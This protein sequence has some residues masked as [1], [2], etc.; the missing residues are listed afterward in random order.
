MFGRT[1][2]TGEIIF[3]I[4]AVCYILVAI[5]DILWNVIKDN[6]WYLLNSG[7]YAGIILIIAIILAP[8]HSFI[9]LF[10]PERLTHFGTLN[11]YHKL[12][13]YLSVILTVV[14]TIDHWERIINDLHSMSVVTGFILGFLMILIMI[15]SL[16]YFRRRHY[17]SVFIFSHWIILA[18]LIITGWF[19]NAILLQISPILIVANIIVNLYYKHRYQVTVNNIKLLGKKMVLIE[20]SV[21]NF[22]YKAGQFIM[23]NIPKIAYFQRHPFTLSSYPSDPDSFSC[24]IK[25]QNKNKNTWTTALVEYV[26]EHTPSELTELK[27]N[28]DG[29]FGGYTLKKQL[30]EYRYVIFVS[31]G[32]GMLFLL[33]I[34]FY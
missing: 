6:V 15:V 25:L 3:F 1:Q 8:K 18:C 23:L 21:K 31:G 19:H 14:H 9:K 24:H 4:V 28:I 13:A 5:S 11:T 12:F 34:F 26:R 20:F 22:K 27:V 7:I 2:T 16:P 29:P 17:N 30:L 10:L 33:N 32:I